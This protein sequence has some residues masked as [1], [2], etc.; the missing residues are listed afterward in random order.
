MST[1][2]LLVEV[3][4]QGLLT[5]CWLIILVLGINGFNFD[6]ELITKLLLPFKDY[7][8]ILLIFLLV[9]GYHIGWIMNFL[10]YRLGS[11]L[12]IN[13]IRR[14]ILGEELQLGDFLIDSRISQTASIEFMKKLRH[15]R[16]VIRLSRSGLINFFMLGVLILIFFNIWL[17]IVFLIL[18]IVSFFQVRVNYLIYYQMV[19]PYLNPE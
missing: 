4:V 6:P 11:F 10:S 8:S 7:S 3:L 2:A 5:T 16:S 12:Y 9:F 18:S 1:T 13:R 14:K 17:G 19:K 15:R